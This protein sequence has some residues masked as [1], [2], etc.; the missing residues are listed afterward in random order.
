MLVVALLADVG[1]V[2][3]SSA[4]DGAC[5]VL[6]GSSPYV[7]AFY[8]IEEGVEEVGGGGM[9]ED[10]VG[11][12]CGAV[13]G[14]FCAGGAFVVCGVGVLCESSS[15]GGVGEEGTGDCCVGDFGAVSLVWCGDVCN[16]VSC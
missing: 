15:K 11:E 5:A 3:C 9:T 7:C 14:S 2:F 12:Y 16:V 10:S 6:G 1:C 8:W 4:G 13:L